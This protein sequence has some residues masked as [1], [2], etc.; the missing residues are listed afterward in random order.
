MSKPSKKP[1]VKGKADPEDGGDY[2]PPHDVHAGSGAHT[3]FYT[4]GT[5]GCFPEGK[6]EGAFSVKVKNG[7][8]IPPLPHTSSCRG[9]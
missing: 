9:A 8:P 6:A 5:G 3:A 4:V 7:G 2:W 1:E